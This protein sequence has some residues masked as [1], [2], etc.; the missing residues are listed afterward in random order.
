[1]R[2]EKVRKLVWLGNVALGGALAW[3]AFTMLTAPQR[4]YIYVRDLKGLSARDA[5]SPKVDVAKPPS[6]YGV[7]LTLPINGDRPPPAIEAGP[8]V[9]EEKADTS[10]LAQ[11]ADFISYRRVLPV[12]EDGN[13]LRGPD[14]REQTSDDSA[15]LL[16]LKRQNGDE[17]WVPIGDVIPG[18]GWKLVDLFVANEER[19]SGQRELVRRAVFVPDEGEDAGKPFPLDFV[20][21][22]LAESARPST[23]SGSGG[24][25]GAGAD[26]GP[27]A[28]DGA[29]LSPEEALERL[30]VFDETATRFR[31]TAA[32][33][34]II[35][36]Q[37]FQ[38]AELGKISSVSWKNP[39]K[40][41]RYEG[42]Q[43]K[44][45]ERR[46][47]A[48]RRGVRE[49]DVLI[50]INGHPVSS[51]SGVMK[52]LKSDE[53]KDHKQYVVRMRTATGEEKQLVYNVED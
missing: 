52:Y 35:S 32:E 33:R 27:S 42:I 48:Y 29:S 25:S 16:K 18:T 8:A 14:G 44:K 21:V 37:S 24:G 10:P 30:P 2:V 47:Y 26:S 19:E 9:A 12:D 4:P 1:M 6:W 40:G 28:L 50:S 49:G 45:I 11:V 36:R 3:Y 34:D 22:P 51:R 53:G 41:G 39:D 7:L 5:S 15:V 20:V 38:E 46:S 23:V 31:V 43:I 17:V 13:V